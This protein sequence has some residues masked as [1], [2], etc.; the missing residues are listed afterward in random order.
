MRTRPALIS[1]GTFAL[2]SLGES[3]GA[4]HDRDIEIIR[5]F[6]A[7]RTPGL[8]T[9]MQFFSTLGNWKVEVP[10]ILAVTALLWFQARRTSAWRYF[11]FCAAGELLYGLAKL[12]FHRQR[13]TV[14]SYLSD[15]GWYSYPS[16]HSMLGPIIWSA[17]LVLLSQRVDSRGIKRL[18]YALAVIIPLAI[19][20]SRIY[21]G[22][23]YPTDVLGGLALGSFWVFVWWD[24]VSGKERREKREE[25][26]ETR[27]E[28]N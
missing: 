19:A 4:T 22:V 17:G 13:P 25:R 6:G 12:L 8:T 10:L 14:L 2:I 16:G 9:V 11:A 21:L 7:W 26:K 5:W 24:A 18:L 23:H 27:E 20:K 15:A 28:A 1:L 3:T